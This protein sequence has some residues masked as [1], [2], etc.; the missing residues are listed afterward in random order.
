MCGICRCDDFDMAVARLAC[1]FGL[2]TSSDYFEY[3][4]VMTKCESGV[5]CIITCTFV[6]MLHARGNMHS[7][8]ACSVGMV[9]L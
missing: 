5:T 9:K 4:C 8:S 2:L 3:L 1:G 6:S 7:Q